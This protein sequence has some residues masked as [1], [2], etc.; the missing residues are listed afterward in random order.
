MTRYILL[1]TSDRLYFAEPHGP[2][3]AEWTDSPREARQWVDFDSCMAAAKTWK[4]IHGLDL[5]VLQM[6]I[7]PH[8]CSVTAPGTPQ[9]MVSHGC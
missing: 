8:F 2:D 3:N 6:A 7:G 9:L 4:M 5:Q 1:R